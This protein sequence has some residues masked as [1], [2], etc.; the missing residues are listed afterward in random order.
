MSFTLL[1]NRIAV[2][3]DPSE[4]KTE[5]GLFVPESGQEVLKYGTVVKVGSGR[6]S[7]TTGELIPIDVAE[8]AKVFYH[9]ASG[10]P[11][12]IEGTDYRILGPTEIIGV[13]DAS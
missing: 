10:Q 4:E 8:G 12:K 7:D 6:R 5:S 2:T 1:D 11:L 9:R 3:D 13:V